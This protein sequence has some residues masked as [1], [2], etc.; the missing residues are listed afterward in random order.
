MDISNIIANEYINEKLEMK[1]LKLHDS[2]SF[3]GS[4]F[5]ASIVVEKRLFSMT[6]EAEK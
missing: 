4:L 1:N 6:M 2:T 5:S 3:P